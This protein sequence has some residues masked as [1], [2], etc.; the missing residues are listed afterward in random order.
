MGRNTA[1]KGREARRGRAR[2]Q[3]CRLR[4]ELDRV[5]CGMGG[6]ERSERWCMSSSVLVKD[7]LPAR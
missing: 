6:P 2:E 5:Q 1:S 4:E 7:A 3:L